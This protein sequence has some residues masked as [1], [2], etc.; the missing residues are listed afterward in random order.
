MAPKQKADPQVVEALSTHTTFDKRLVK[1]LAT[2]GT[3]VNIPQGWSI[4]METTPAD[5]A[6]IVLAGTV[7]IRKGSDVVAHLG[8]GDVFGEIA[9]V[10]HSLRNASAVAATDV[11]ALRLGEDAIAE[12]SAQDNAFADT[13][14]SHAESR[15]SAD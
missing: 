14:R 7:E 10:N 12:L 3:A 2:I 13:L 11:R 4:I 9:L 15:L 8:A 1:K 6:Y 5:S